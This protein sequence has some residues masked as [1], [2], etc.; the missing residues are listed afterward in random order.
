MPLQEATHQNI[1]AREHLI[2][3][4]LHPTLNGA[5]AQHPCSLPTKPGRFRDNIN[6]VMYADTPKGLLQ[7]TFEVVYNLDLQWEGGGD[8]WITLQGDMTLEPQD[9]LQHPPRIRL[10]LADK[11]P[12]H[13]AAHH[14]LMRDLDAH[15]TLKSLVPTLAKTLDI[16]ETYRPMPL[17]ILVSS[18]RTWKVRASRTHGGGPFSAHTFTNGAWNHMRRGPNLPQ[19]WNCVPCIQALGIPI[20]PLACEGRPT[21]VEKP[22]QFPGFRKSTTHCIILC[23]LST[24]YP[25]CC[26]AVLVIVGTLGYQAEEDYQGT[27]YRRVE[28]QCSVCPIIIYYIIIIIYIIIWLRAFFACVYATEEDPGENLRPRQE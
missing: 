3:K 20:L 10:E 8:H 12:K 9:P 16:T 17:S 25:C 21:L 7:T 15:T 26:T 5:P 23:T 18:P 2:E 13:T 24:F 6:G 11:S 19:S 1:D 22:A 14:F 27:A 28:L 4:I